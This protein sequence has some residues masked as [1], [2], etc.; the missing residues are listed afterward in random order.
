[1]T[2]SKEWIAHFRKNLTKLRID[3]TLLPD[4][5]HEERKKLIRSLQA[6]QLGETSDG[7]N[8][9]R[10]SSIYAKKIQDADYVDAVKLFIKEEQK[11]G[12]NLGKYLD[13]I[14]EKRLKK[15]WGDS[16]FRKVRY[17]NTS[18]EIWTV[19]V[20]IVESFAQ[21]YYKAIADATSC[22]LLKQIC[23]DILIDEA[24]HIRFQL[25]RLCIVTSDRPAIIH[26]LILSAYRLFFHII[27]L[28]IWIGHG[29]AFKAG[30]L[31][32]GLLLRKSRR[33]FNFISA[34][35]SRYNHEVK[36]QKLQSVVA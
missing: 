1:M 3:W 30:G 2:T 17:F 24:H 16:L 23:E 25:E 12:E 27:L 9:L 14:G 20:I 13:K 8:L 11:H 18:I 32:F 7:A 19:T 34:R 28:A 36:T 4:I 6:W 26:Q 29:K 10:A 15:D 35:L 33:K 21:L 5:S 22:R 31:S